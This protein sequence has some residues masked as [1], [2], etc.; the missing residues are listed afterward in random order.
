MQTRLCVSL[1]QSTATVVSLFCVPNKK[2]VR[3]KRQFPDMLIAK[4][5]N[6]FLGL[7]TLQR[8][9]V[10]LWTQQQMAIDVQRAERQLFQTVLTM[11]D[12][13]RGVVA[14][15]RHASGP[16]LSHSD[17]ASS[18][19]LAWR[20]EGEGE[21]KET[22]G[23]EIVDSEMLRRREAQ[24]K[25]QE[26]VSQLALNVNKE[27][28]RLLSLVSMLSDADEALVD[29][30]LIARNSEDVRLAEEVVRLYDEAAAL[31]HSLE[32]EILAAEVD[33]V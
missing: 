6:F 32:S 23:D 1:A 8:G 7:C 16:P 11:R 17:A 20:E 9:S 15:Q 5:K 27:V 26:R 2:K 13:L 4:R 18:D 14:P 22:A 25:E 31:S 21:G 33:P 28:E 10:D 24:R 12:A 30:H 29:E 3:K 19:R